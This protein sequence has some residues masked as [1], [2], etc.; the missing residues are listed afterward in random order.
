MTFGGWDAG[1][2]MTCLNETRRPSPVALVTA[3]LRV[4]ATRKS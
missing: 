3:S 1:D 2:T 4:Q